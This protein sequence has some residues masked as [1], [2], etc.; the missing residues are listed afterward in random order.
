MKLILLITLFCG[1]AN[2]ESL[3][4]EKRVP[5]NKCAVL[6]LN[7]DCDD[8]G[9]QIEEGWDTVSPPSLKQ[10]KNVVVRPDCKLVGWSDSGQ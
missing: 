1:I 7:E 4:K 3:C 9:S 6:Y 10:W 2:A 5:G 8:E